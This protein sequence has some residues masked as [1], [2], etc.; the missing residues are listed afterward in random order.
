MKIYMETDNEREGKNIVEGVIDI[1]HHLNVIHT[2]LNA[3]YQ[4]HS[5]KSSD[6]P[7][8]HHFP[9]DVLL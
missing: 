6:T 7:D 3:T 4:P 9:E 1:N 8:S 2:K 5:E